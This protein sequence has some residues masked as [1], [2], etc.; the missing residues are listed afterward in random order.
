[1][2][3]FQVEQEKQISE[4]ID[5]K[6]QQVLELKEQLNKVSELKN[7]GSEDQKSWW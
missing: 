7:E 1:M 5:E 4:L 2:L 3:L 6:Q